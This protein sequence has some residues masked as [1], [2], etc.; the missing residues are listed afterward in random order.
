LVVKNGVNSAPRT[1]SGCRA[2]VGDR[3]NAVAQR[4][5]DLAVAMHRVDRVTEHIENDLLDL[6]RIDV[7]VS[8]IV[9]REIDANRAIGELGTQQRGHALDEPA[10]GVALFTGG[11]C[12]RRPQTRP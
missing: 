6:R 5:A 1:E 3:E 9:Q 11:G 4:C 2:A 8:T 7:I 10:T 12:A